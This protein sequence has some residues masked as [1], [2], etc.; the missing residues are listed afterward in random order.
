MT[1]AAAG[2]GETPLAARRLLAWLAGRPMQPCPWC[3]TERAL[4]AIAPCGAPRVRSVLNKASGTYVG[5][6]ICHRRVA[7]AFLPRRRRP[8]RSDGT[9]RLPGDVASCALLFLGFDVVAVA[10]DR[11]QRLC[12]GTAPLTPAERA[13]REDVID[14]VGPRAASSWLPRTIPRCRDHGV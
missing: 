11:M 2:G 13:E 4:K 9:A 3:A 12:S 14:T 5:C 1:P 10:R 7:Q 6:P 8:C